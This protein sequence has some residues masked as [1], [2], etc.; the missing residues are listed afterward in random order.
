MKER[1]QWISSFQLILRHRVSILNCVKCPRAMTLQP[2][3]CNHMFALSLAILPTKILFNILPTNT[4]L[5][6][7]PICLGKSLLT[8]D[9]Y[10]RFLEQHSAMKTT[11]TTTQLS[12]LRTLMKQNA[13]DAYII[14][15]E[16]AHA[17][18]YIAPCDERI[19]RLSSTPAP[20]TLLNQD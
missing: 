16:D 6:R 20:T 2:C 11:S 1:G 3:P 5:T 4:W 19:V 14:L 13:I 7:W 15:P 18:E 12:A 17:S 10:P 9:P 8:F